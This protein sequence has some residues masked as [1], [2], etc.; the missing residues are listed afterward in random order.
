[1]R[2][3]M[4]GLA[5]VAFTGALACKG[6][7]PI[8]PSTP[9][10]PV[11]PVVPVVPVVVPPNLTF[12]SSAIVKGAA[13]DAVTTGLR[14]TG[15]D[16]SYRVEFWASQLNVVNAAPKLVATTDVVAVTASYA[17]T[18]TWTVPRQPGYASVSVAVLYSRDLNSAVFR[19]TGRVALP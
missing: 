3:I 16:G 6:E 10:P 9:T 12:T 18:V 14:N 5:L 19:E 17:Q 15:G 1:M 4:L 8:A 2:T 7:S 13:Q 11:T